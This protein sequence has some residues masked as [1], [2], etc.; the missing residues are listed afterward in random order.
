MKQTPILSNRKELSKASNIQ[1]SDCLC[2]HKP[3]SIQNEE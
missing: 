2:N 3:V 1:E